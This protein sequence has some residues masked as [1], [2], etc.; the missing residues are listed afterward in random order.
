[1]RRRLAAESTR[2][3]MLLTRIS[4]VSRRSQPVYRGTR[5]KVKRHECLHG[6]QHLHLI[7]S[8]PAKNRYAGLLMFSVRQA[9]PIAYKGLRYVRITV[10]R[11]PPSW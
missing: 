6:F 10:A 1:M 8:R 11:H 5:V 2:A 9:L 3:I 7:R 4:R